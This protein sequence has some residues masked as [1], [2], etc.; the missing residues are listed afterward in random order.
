[1]TKLLC[2]Q[3]EVKMAII[4]SSDNLFDQVLGEM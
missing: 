4:Y 3:S 1:M 2:A